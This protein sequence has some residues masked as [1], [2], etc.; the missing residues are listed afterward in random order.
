MQQDQWVNEVLGS[1]EGLQKA[2]G[3]PYLH[4]RVLAALD[5]TTP[6]KRGPLKPLYALASLVLILLLLNVFLWSETGSASP[7]NNSVTTTVSEYDLTAI[8][9]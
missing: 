8:D 4:T 2:P 6:I 7:E 1:L 5:T 3:N 9:Y